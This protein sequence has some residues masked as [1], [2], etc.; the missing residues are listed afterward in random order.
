MI[1]VGQIWHWHYAHVTKQSP[2]L[3]NNNKKWIALEYAQKQSC[4]KGAGAL[5]F[6]HFTLLHTR[7][8]FKVSSFGCVCAHCLVGLFSNTQ[9]TSTCTVVRAPSSQTQNRVHVDPPDDEN[10]LGLKLS[11]EVLFTPIINLTWFVMY[12][13]QRHSLIIQ[14]AEVSKYLLSCLCCLWPNLTTSRQLKSVIHMRLCCCY[15]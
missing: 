8:T 6:L 1:C 7:K 11:K 13:L 12:L 3:N 15:L 5:Y 10:D 9:V 4:F 14:M 2:I